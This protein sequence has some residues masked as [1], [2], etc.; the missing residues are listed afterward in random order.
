VVQGATQPDP[1]ERYLIGVAPWWR[2]QQ[3]DPPSA[4]AQTCNITY[5][6][7]L[8]ERLGGFDET[9]PEAAGE[10]T[11][12]RFRALA[13]GAEHVGAPAALTFHAVAD[14]S[15]LAHAR[16]ASRWSGL[17]YLYKRHPELREDALLGVFWKERHALFLL[18][19]AGALL[20]ARR[21]GFLLLGAPYVLR[22]R[23]PRSGGPRAYARALLELPGHALIDAA[24]VAA[25]AR[26]SIRYGTLFL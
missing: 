20:G 7:E 3:I 2:T 25:L 24:E 9:L 10:D 11:D 1:D 5:P 12:L 19:A 14:H 8:L 26:G 22:L 15:L 23:P 17:A 6:R 16:L 21:R 4:L 18:A 13:A